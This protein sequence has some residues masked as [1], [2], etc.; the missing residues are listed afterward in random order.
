MAMSSRKTLWLIMAVMVLILGQVAVLGFI[1]SRFVAGRGAAQQAQAR[2]MQRPDIKE[3]RHFPNIPPPAA[4]PVQAQNRKNVSTNYKPQPKVK[5]TGPRAEPPQ[6]S[7]AGGLFT[8]EV[9]VELKSKSEKVVIRYTLNGSDPTESSPAYDGAPLALRNSA[10]L[11]AACFEPGLAPSLSVS[12]AFTAMDADAAAFSSDLPIVVISTHQQSIGTVN[13]APTSIRFIPTVN[14]R[15]SLFG[16]ADFD[17]R[18]DL[19]RRGYSSLRL[20]KMSLTLKMRDDDGDKEKASIFGLPSDSDWV[21]YAPYADKTLL[22]DV[23][24]YELSNQMGRYAPRTRFVELFLRRS[25]GPL[26]YRLDYQGVYV[27]VEKIK[28]GKERVNIEK[29]GTNDLTEPNIAGGYI[30]KRDHGASGGG[31][32]GG[33]PRQSNDGVGFVTPHGLHLFHVEPDENEM[34]AAQRQWIARHFAEFERALHGPKF[35]DPTVGYAKY[36]DVDAFIDLFWHAELTKNVDAFRYS[37]FVH[38]PRGGKIT[39]GPAWDWNLSFGN[40]DYYD[41]YETG[42]WYY[43]N[44]RDTEIAWIYRLRQDPE[45]MQRAQDRWAE[46]RR[47]PFATDKMMARVDAMRAQL[48]ESQVRN[49]RKWA[50]MGREIRPNYYVGPTYDAEVNWMKIWL[51]DRA[52]WL[53]KQ[54][55]AAPKISGPT[56]GGFA[57]TASPGDIYYTLDGSD[58]RAPGGKISTGAKKY[59]GPI[60]LSDGMKLT[61]R[62]TRRDTWSAPAKAELPARN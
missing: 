43:E 27:L 19:K 8:N 56:N 18:A 50:I 21:L 23:L 10:L 26:N 1:V 57:L 14:G 47:G 42:G 35:A 13:Y 25:S 48:Q 59:T 51:K 6:F 46:L 15:A 61:A 3:P 29:L 60:A 9:A 17:G 32:G 33:A 39:V 44:L 62:L 41:A 24:G 49:F 4:R 45:F 38:K 28:R 12:H 5:P 11:R 58:P 16:A 55:M 52:A 30:L 36:L 40:A 31:R 54:Q 22:R 20:P 37:A 7:R 34:P 2:A 53:D